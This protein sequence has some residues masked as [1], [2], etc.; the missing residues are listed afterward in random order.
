MSV[1]KH[2]ISLTYFV[3]VVQ[4]SANPKITKISQIKN[5][6]E[7]DPRIDFYKKFRDGIIKIHKEKGDK[8]RLSELRNSIVDEKKIKNYGDIINGYNKWWGKKELIWFDPPKKYYENS[9]VEVSINP[10]LGLI[11]DGQ[12]YIIKLYLKDEPLSKFRVDPS[13]V[14]MELSL[15][16]YCESSDVIGILDV[17]KS[18]FFRVTADIPL[19]KA[20]ID[21][22]LGYI[23]NMWPHV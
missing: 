7:Y 13:T 6:K 1:F 8:K 14:L 21:S 20:M 15:R 3:D 19:T 16:D 4:K 11:I 10:E 17:R 2:E 5:R 22:E 23:A 9:G 18:K 12:R